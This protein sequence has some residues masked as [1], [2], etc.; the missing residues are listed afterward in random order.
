[1]GRGERGGLDARVCARATLARRGKSAAQVGGGFFAVDRSDLT[2]A[3]VALEARIRGMEP[4]L[5]VLAI[6]ENER[7]VAV[8]VKFRELANGFKPIQVAA[9]QLDAIA[10]HGAG[11]LR[12]PA[13]I[14]LGQAVETIARLAR[15]RP[16]NR[17]ARRADEA[18]RER[19]ERRLKRSSRLQDIARA[20]SDTLQ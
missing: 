13:P 5:D 11:V 18:R 17:Q 7:L 14:E 20:A 10:M 1:M 19:Q 6:D 8:A 3:Q 4:A 2:W 15:E 12:A 16:M 9:D